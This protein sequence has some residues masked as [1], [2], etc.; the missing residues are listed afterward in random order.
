MTLHTAAGC[1]SEKWPVAGCYLNRTWPG[2]FT[3]SKQAADWIAR[4]FYAL[5]CPVVARLVTAMDA[6]HPAKVYMQSGGGAN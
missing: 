5:T 1:T 4:P 2:W 3:F 6:S